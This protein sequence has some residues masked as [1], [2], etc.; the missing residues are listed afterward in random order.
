MNVVATAAGMW[1]RSSS[2]R[3]CR[4]PTRPAA[5]SPSRDPAAC[6]ARCRRADRGRLTAVTPEGIPGWRRMPRP[7]QRRGAPGRGR[8]PGQRPR[9]PSRRLRFASPVDLVAWCLKHRC[10]RDSFSPRARRC[11]ERCRRRGDEA[12]PPAPALHA[13][14]LRVRRRDA[15]TT[16]P[17][18]MPQRLAD[19]CPAAFWET[20]RPEP[21]LP[22]RQPRMAASARQRRRHR[23]ASAPL[24]AAGAQGARPRRCPPNVS[25]TRPCWRPLT[26]G[27]GPLPPAIN[28]GSGRPVTVREVADRAAAIGV[29]AGFP[30][31]RVVVQPAGQAPLSHSC[32][33]RHWPS[34]CSAFG[35]G[36]PLIRR[37]ATCS[38]CSRLTARALTRD[39]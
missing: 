33:R 2:R 25:G 16:Q 10:P 15:S 13:R 30:P 28:I 7:G 4:Q 8:P 11:T 14:C 23:A 17:A 3:A 18:R 38:R 26:H 1:A 35:R 37:F 32:W 34:R 21:L 22:R 27:N 9:R 36:S 6:Q 20:R 19:W 24:P 12:M 5:S 39:R 31:L 29:A